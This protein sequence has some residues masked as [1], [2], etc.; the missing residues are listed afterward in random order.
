MSVAEGAIKLERFASANGTIDPPRHFD[1]IGF[2]KR[3]LV[4]PTS[5]MASCTTSQVAGP[6]HFAQPVRG[7]LLE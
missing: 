2:P 3:T 6:P 7:H 1:A 4:I 5:F